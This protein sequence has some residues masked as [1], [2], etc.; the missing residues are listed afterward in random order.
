MNAHLLA[1]PTGSSSTYTPLC[2]VEF[3]G[4]SCSTV[5]LFVEKSGQTGD[6]L[7]LKVFG[8]SDRTK[9]S[10]YAMSSSLNAV[11]ILLRPVKTVLPFVLMDR[12]YVNG[13]E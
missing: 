9:E 2:T 6:R 5:R 11:S 12:G 3:F 1:S 8:S 4:S 13:E 7:S 10:Q